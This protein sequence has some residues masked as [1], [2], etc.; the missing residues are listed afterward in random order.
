VALPLRG[1]IRRC[2]MSVTEARK[3][4]T[5]SNNFLWK[6]GSY[7]AEM[8]SSGREF[9]ISDGQRLRRLD[10]Q[11][12]WTWLAYNSSIASL[13]CVL[14]LYSP[15]MSRRTSNLT[16]GCR[17]RPKH[18]PHYTGCMHRAMKTW[19][20]VS[21]RW[22]R[23]DMPLS[24]SCSVLTGDKAKFHGNSFSSYLLSRSKSLTSS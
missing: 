5:Q 20:A 18:L 22:Q 17:A 7:S 1:L 15:V 8:A 3:R 16:S 6:V 14:G 4:A 19:Q 9:Q 12:C 24:I 13:V 2:R 23:N 11:R 10:C 21:P